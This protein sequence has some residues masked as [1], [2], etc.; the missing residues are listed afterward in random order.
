MYFLTRSGANTVRFWWGLSS[1]LVGSRHRTVCSY[2]LSFMQERGAEL[3]I[4]PH[5]D[6]F[7]SPLGTH[8]PSLNVLLTWIPSFRPE[9]RLLAYVIAWVCPDPP[10]YPT[11]A[12]DLL[13]C[14][15]SSSQLQILSL[16][17]LREKP[18][19]WFEMSPKKTR[20]QLPTA[21]FKL[22]HS[23]VGCL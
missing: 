11:T 13:K 9:S 16:P 21:C 19:I 7:S 10:S 6:S 12:Q 23:L 20:I 14:L 2:D 4:Q 3:I 18:G 8:G 1:W 17:R 15:P 5:A 22:C